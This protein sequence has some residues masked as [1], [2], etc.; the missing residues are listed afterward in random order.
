MN[1]SAPM[2]AAID[3][4][5]AVRGTTSPNPWVGAA[6]V[7]DGGIVAIGATS[8]HGGPHAEAAALANV[9]ASGAVLYTTLEPCMP[10]EGKRTRPCVDVIIEAGVKRV[11]IGIEDPHAP[12]R[13]QGVAY[14]RARGIEVAIGDG[15]ASV[16]ELL[17]P[18]LKFR[19]TS[20]P[21]LIAKFAISLDG[22]VGAPAAGVTWLTA[23]CCL[24][25]LSVFIPRMV[26]GPAGA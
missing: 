22:K 10:F 16:T 7:R 18:Y 3:A 1:P 5:R 20:R 4:A 12:V 26:A 8:P 11:V 23:S 15:A 21:Y 2:Q 17:R 9:D 24:V 14:L 25:L 6:L 19:Q 13:G